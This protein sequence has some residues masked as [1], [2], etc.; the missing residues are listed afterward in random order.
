MGAGYDISH[1]KFEKITGK[2]KPKRRE[3]YSKICTLIHTWSASVFLLC[4]GGKPR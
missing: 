3:I 4:N 1:F 2:K